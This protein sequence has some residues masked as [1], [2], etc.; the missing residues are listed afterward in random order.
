[1]SQSSAIT[2]KLFSTLLWGK[3]QVGITSIVLLVFIG[4]TAIEA[5]TA[6][7]AKRSKAKGSISGRV[8]IQG[9]P[10]ANLPV[11][12]FKDDYLLQD[13]PI[14]KT[15]TDA[16]GRFRFSDLQSN[17]YWLKVLSSNYVAPG[18]GYSRQGRR[19]TV[20]EGESIEDADWDMIPG[21]T[22]S[23]RITDVEGNPVADEMIHLFP[24]N[25]DHPHY[26]PLWFDGEKFKTDETGAYRV[27]GIPPGR[28]V[29]GIGEDIAR[30]TG[31]VSYK[32]DILA[33]QGRVGHDYY[34][35][36]TLYPG[37]GQREQAHI[38][39]VSSGDETGSIDFT[40]S[41]RRRAHKVSGRVIEER[42]GNPVR[43]CH[44][45]VGYSY[46]N[47]SLSSYSLNGPSDVND[48]GEFSFSG[49]LPGRFFVNALFSEG[50]DLYG[51]RIDFEVKE[52]DV[53]GLV[54]RVHRGLTV[55]GTVEIEGASTADAL[56]KRSLLKL[57]ISTPDPNI[58]TANVSKEV[59]VNA[60]GTFRIVGLPRGPV[61]ISACFCDVCRFFAMERIEYA[62]DDAKNDVKLAEKGVGADSRTLNVEVNMQRVRIVLRYKAASILCHVNVIGALPPDVHLMVLIDSGIGKGGWSGWREVDANGNMLETGLEPGNYDLVVGDGARRFTEIKSIK[63]ANNQQTKVSFTIDASKIQKRD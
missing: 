45:Q 38:F 16:E 25:G 42:T 47:G 41:K 10:A 34:Y 14:T 51:N 33:A 18:D 39:E 5:M 15:E 56:V 29:I 60:D 4:A 43:D 35:E 58:R 57:K 12:L 23:G 22:I 7:E 21:G 13:A 61:E 55:S 19:V 48:K 26:D 44:I 1:M 30:L 50:S 20:R 17:H 24:V 49:F 27:F 6:Q 59:A 2:T 52:E 46:I 36:Q 9:K 62:S 40:V 11:G 53:E 54:I 3:R 32:N 8:T 31:A 37:V 28:Y 63:V